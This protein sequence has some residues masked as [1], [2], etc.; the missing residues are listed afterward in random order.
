MH[1]RKIEGRQAQVARAL[2]LNALFPAL[3]PNAGKS[4]PLAVT[5]L[6]L[7]RFVSLVWLD[8]KLSRA[9]TVHSHCLARW[10]P[11]LG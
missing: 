10:G 8:C 1:K 4:L 2:D 3:L 6:S 11:D 9:E 7:P 5:L